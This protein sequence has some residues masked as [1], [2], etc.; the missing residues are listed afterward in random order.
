MKK[1]SVLV[2]LFFA[3]FSGKMAAQAAFSVALL[4]ADTD[5]I[6]LAMGDSV[7]SYTI[8][9]VNQGNA[10]F[11]GF[12]QIMASYNADPGVYPW[13]FTNIDAANPIAVGDTLTFTH[14]DV[15][16]ADR[17]GGGDNI[18]LVWPNAG[19]GAQILDTGSTHIFV[20]NLVSRQNPQE[21]DKRV[22]VY[23][24]PAREALRFLWVDPSY[25]LEQVRLVNALGQEVFST[26]ESVTEIQVEGLPEGLYFLELRYLD[27]MQGIFRVRV[28]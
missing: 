4:E 15:V 5:T 12:I 8:K 25:Q 26:H 2:L 24:N 22:R 23:P 27:G 11:S 17:Y 9:L 19:S 10:S 20:R 21:L 3:V 14:D 16:S 18:I 28:E 6:D 7:V 13:E 1:I